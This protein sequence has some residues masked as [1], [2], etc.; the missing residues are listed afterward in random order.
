MEGF[1]VDERTNSFIWKIEDVSIDF[2]EECSKLDI[3]S[4]EEEVHRRG[5]GPTPVP[6]HS[7]QASQVFN[8]SMGF[9][10]GESLESLKQRYNELRNRRISLRTNSSSPDHQVKQNAKN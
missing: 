10:R 9:E 4:P 6:Q 8:F 3:E 7:P 5:N 2:E 1:V